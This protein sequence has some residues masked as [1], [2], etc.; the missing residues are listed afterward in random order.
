MANECQFVVCVL[1]AVR[2]VTLYQIAAFVLSII[3]FAFVDKNSFVLIKMHGKT[4]TKIIF[5]QYILKEPD[6]NRPLG[7]PTRI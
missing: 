5:I 2:R 1:S 7:R 6:G 4:T 3:I